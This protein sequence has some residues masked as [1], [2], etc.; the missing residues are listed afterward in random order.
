MIVYA[1]RFTKIESDDN[2]EDVEREIP[3]LKAYTLFNVA[4]IQGF[5]A[6][7]R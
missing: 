3:F 2:G 5:S 7:L 4:Q 1:D 6:L